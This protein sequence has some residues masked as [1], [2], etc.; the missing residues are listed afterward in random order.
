[1]WKPQDPRAWIL[2]Y[3]GQTE[4]TCLVV[5]EICFIPIS[6]I[7]NLNPEDDKQLFQDHIGRQGW[8]WEFKLK[9]VRC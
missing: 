8:A 2:L 4:A 1:M 6:Q 7:N 9:T 3:L 5:L